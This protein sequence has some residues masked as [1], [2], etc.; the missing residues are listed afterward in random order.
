MRVAL[1]TDHASPLTAPGDAYPADPGAGVGALATALAG[2]GV[3]A[4]VYAAGPA[5]ASTHRGGSA[6]RPRPAALCPGAV[7][8]PLSLP[9]AGPAGP[10]AAGAAAHDPDALRIRELADQLAARWRDHPPDLVHAHSWAA[11][12]AAL[13]GGRELGLPHVQ[14]FYSLAVQDGPGA[15]ARRVRLELALARS[16][17]AVLVGASAE[18]SVLARLGV[19]QA[20]IRVMPPGVDTSHF[21]PDGPAASRDSRPRL[22]TVVTG[23]ADNPAPAAALRALAAVPGTE[24]VIAGGPAAGQLAR[25]RGYQALSKLASQLGVTDR[26][27]FTGQLTQAGMPALMRSADAALSLSPGGPLAQVTIEATACGVPVI[28]VSAGAHQDAVLDGTTGYLV[29]STQPAPLARRIRQLLATPLREGMAIA[30][31]SRARDRYSWERIGTETLAVYEAAR[32]GPA[33]AA[34][35]VAGAAA[36]PVDEC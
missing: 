21:Q 8:E 32:P 5:P 35:G 17:R 11:G 24:L 9:A 1:V 20:T 34:G 28:A 29:A 25:D 19:P 22:L 27:T 31:A 10:P 13:A 12:V 23:L 15:G 26:V 3:Q 7:I 33:R 18:S 4:T 36:G 16:A 2:L 6:A 14:T 30:A